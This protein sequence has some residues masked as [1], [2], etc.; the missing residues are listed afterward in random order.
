MSDPDVTRGDGY[1]IS[2]LDRLGE[3]YGFRKVRTPM[4]VDAFGVN[5]VV[6]P[7]DYP[8]RNHFHD[9]QEELYFVHRGTIEFLFGDGP[10]RVAPLDDVL[11]V[12][13]TIGARRLLG[14]VLVRCGVAW[15]M[16][17]ETGVDE[18]GLPVEQALVQG[19]YLGVPGAVAE[20]LLGDLPEAVAPAHGVVDSW[21]LMVVGG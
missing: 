1:S 16:Q 13:S 8:T 12:G 19:D 5:G 11:I 9:E 21:L 15:E 2:S 4:G 7:P 18:V 6:T 20:L 17:H 3:G 10:Q 14:R